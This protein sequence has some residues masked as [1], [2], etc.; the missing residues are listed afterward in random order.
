MTRQDGSEDYTHLLD[1]GLSIKYVFCHLYL[2]TDKLITIDLIMIMTYFSNFPSQILSIAGD[3]W[4]G[5]F[6]KA[7]TFP[8]FQ[9]ATLVQLFLEGSPIDVEVLVDEVSLTDDSSGADW[10]EEANERIDQIRKR[11]MTISVG[12]SGKS[13]GVNPF[14]LKIELTQLSHLFPFGTALNGH[15]IRSCVE[16]RVDDLYCSF[17]RDNFNYIV[18]ENAMKWS[19]VEPHRGEFK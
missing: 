12:T 1:E 6:E 14:N 11:N 7:V 8:N 4:Q 13:E 3:D 17:A 5:H 15:K 18:L 9:D 2:I 10:K 19:S 16:N